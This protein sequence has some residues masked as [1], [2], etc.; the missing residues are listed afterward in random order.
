ME[1][2]VILNIGRYRLELVFS[3]SGKPRLTINGKKL[4]RLVGSD[5]CFKSLNFFSEDSARKFESGLTKG[6]RWHLP[7]VYNLVD[8][9]KRICG[10]APWGPELEKFKP[11]LQEYERWYYANIAKGKAHRQTQGQGGQEVPSW[12]GQQA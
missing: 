7:D 3:G 6:S 9:L 8:I 4:T 5:D 2:G 10:D 12:T 11:T 1:S